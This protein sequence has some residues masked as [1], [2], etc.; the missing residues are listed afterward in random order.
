MEFDELLRQ[1]RSSTLL[2]VDKLQRFEIWDSTKGL[3][4]YSNPFREFD[5]ENISENIDVFH[6]NISDQNLAI[7]EI[8][9]NVSGLTASKLATLYHSLAETGVDP[10][11][12][13]WFTTQI[14]L[15]M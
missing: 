12:A 11:Q 10:E 1:L 2:S 8:G 9:E 13:V 7:N 6:F 3:P 14:G 5:L 15:L 4:T